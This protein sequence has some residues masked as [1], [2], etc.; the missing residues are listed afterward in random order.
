MDQWMSH[1]SCWTKLKRAVAWFLKMRDLLKKLK[2][3]RKEPNTLSGG[4]RVDQFKK[5]F[6][7]TQLTCEGSAETEIVKYCQTVASSKVLR[8]TWRC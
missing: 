8:K 7:G 1:Y 6:K 4:S 3:K 2:A 5:A